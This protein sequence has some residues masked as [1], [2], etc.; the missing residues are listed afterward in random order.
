[1]KSP[2]LSLRSAA[3]RQRIAAS[4]LTVAITLLGASHAAAQSNGRTSI[5]R[6]FAVVPITITSVTPD[7][8]TGQLIASGLAGT[9]AFTTPLTVTPR[10]VAGA[11]CPILDLS[12]GPID[13]TLL[14]LNVRT[15]PI[16][17]AVTAHQGGGLLGDLLCNV[18]NLL[19]PTTPIAAVLDGLSATDRAR[20]LN[21]LTTILNQVFDRLTANDANLAATCQVLSLSLGPLDLTLLGL[22]V[23]LNNCSAGPVT[24]DITAIPGGG[25]L[26][27]LLCGLSGLLSGGTSP[28]SVAVQR[29]LFQI[30]LLL[31]ALA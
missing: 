1:M 5:P 16:C 27:D 11:A 19:S 4:C 10:Q 22:Q 2:H 15:S 17:L 9:T 23:E 6:S 30:A 29:L 7:P 21:G 31:G 26:G 25:L 8:A 13:L 18:A 14:G 24:V 3:A 28:L 12:L 20:V